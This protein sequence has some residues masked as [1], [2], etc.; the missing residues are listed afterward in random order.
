MNMSLFDFNPFDF[1]KARPEP[2]VED[3][4]I[5]LECDIEESISDWIE[6]FMRLSKHGEFKRARL[7]FDD[8]LRP[9]LSLFPVAAEYAHFLLEQ[10]NF[11]K[12]E[13]FLTDYLQSRPSFD[14]DEIQ[15]LRLL[16][17]FARL[18]TGGLLNE[19]FR[20][21]VDANRC[22]PGLTIGAADDVQVGDLTV[23]STSIVLLNPLN[24][25]RSSSLSFELF[26]SSYQHRRQTLANWIVHGRL[27]TTP[28]EK[29]CMNNT[30]SGCDYTQKISH[31]TSGVCLILSCSR[32]RLSIGTQFKEAFEPSFSGVLTMKQRS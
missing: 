31:G 12:L 24:S 7:L 18:H 20:E 13:N 2:Q 15:L 19:A 1:W 16:R 6:Q 8:V 3:T 4:V 23:L 21:V 17:A 9:H 5:H 27:A 30:R 26:I 29:S 25:V 32:Q 28:S 22:L 11:G 14:R 10:G